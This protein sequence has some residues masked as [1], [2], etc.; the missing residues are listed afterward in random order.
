AST[1]FS[2]SMSLH[3]LPVF[4]RTFYSVRVAQASRGHSGK[5]PV[6]L[7]VPLLHSVM[8]KAMNL[9][10]SMDARAFDAE[11]VQLTHKL[12]MNPPDWVALLALFLVI[13]VKI[14]TL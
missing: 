12:R 7:V 13:A 4:E 14:K 1:A 10:L 11:R 6:P 2:L 5:N 8:R 3:F 9:S